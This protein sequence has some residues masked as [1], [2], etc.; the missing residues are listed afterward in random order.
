MT[1]PAKPAPSPPPRPG[2]RKVLTPH[3]NTLKRHMT[4][5]IRAQARRYLERPDLPP[6]IRGAMARNEVWLGM[7][8]EE[9]RLVLGMPTGSEPIAGKPGHRA[10]RYRDEGWVFSF[11]DRGL[12]YEYVEE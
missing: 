5:E 1:E 6:E 3:P 12:L 9:V 4:D 2:L 11:D 7:T 10:L 8:E